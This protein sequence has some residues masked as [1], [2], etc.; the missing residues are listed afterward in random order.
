MGLGW[1]VEFTNANQGIMPEAYNIWVQYVQSEEKNLDNTFEGRIPNFALFYFSWTPPN[2]VHQYQNHLPAGKRLSTISK[3][4][5]N[6]QPWVLCL[7]A[8]KYAE[9]ISTM[10]SNFQTWPE[11]VDGFIQVVKQTN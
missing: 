6:T 2:Q 8:Y 11:C 3:R 5:K 9:A 1:K 10:Y 4:L 7:Q